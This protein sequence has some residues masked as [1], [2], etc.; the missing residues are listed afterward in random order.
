MLGCGEEQGECF[1]VS[2]G[3]VKSG[4]DAAEVFE[5]VEEAL[6]E[7]ALFV[8]GG[9]EAA[10]C[11]GG[12]AS[13]HDGDGARSGDGVDRALA[14]IAFVGQN[15]AGVEPIE[16]A[17]DLRDVVALAAGPDDADRPI[18]RASCRE[19]VCQYV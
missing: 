9:V 18:G 7:V 5:F 6:E 16:Q 13:R 1:V 10:P 2:G 15:E 11:G 17:L 12:R 4:G 3:L 19:R 8:E 14:I